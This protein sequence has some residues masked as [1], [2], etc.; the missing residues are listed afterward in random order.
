MM[1]KTVSEISQWAYEKS[2]R[3]SSAGW[4]SILI[5][6]KNTNQSN[7]K[8]IINLKKSNTFMTNKLMQGLMRGQ[9][10]NIY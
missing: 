9:S 7:L 5:T 2:Q 10:I 4:D 8:N 1:M 6:W 3:A